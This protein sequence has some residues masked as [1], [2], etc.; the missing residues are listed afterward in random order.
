MT[1]A[2]LQKRVLK[3]A[4]THGI[5]ARK[6][7]A[8]NY[9]GFPD[10]M[11]ARDARILFL[12]LKTPRGTGVLSALQKASLDEMRKAGLQVAVADTYDDAIHVIENTLNAHP[13]KPDTGTERRDR[14]AL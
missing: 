13:E 7:V 1:E 8:V 6:L 3:Y 4:R 12:E 5:F 14:A 9:R 11:L 2:D 10:L